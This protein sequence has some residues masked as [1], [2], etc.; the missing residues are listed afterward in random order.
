MRDRILKKQLRRC[1]KVL[2]KSRALICLLTEK[3]LEND[4]ALSATEL[5]DLISEYNKNIKDY[6]K[7][8]KT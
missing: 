6:K 2:K 5:T 7:K 3:A 1:K 8:Y 4:D